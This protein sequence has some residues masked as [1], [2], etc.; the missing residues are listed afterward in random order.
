MH[1]FKNNLEHMHLVDIIIAYYQRDSNF[2]AY[3][4]VPPIFCGDK[5]S[6]YADFSFKTGFMIEMNTY[7]LEIIKGDF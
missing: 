1:Y 7:H 5:D 3:V 4:S 6:I 2:I